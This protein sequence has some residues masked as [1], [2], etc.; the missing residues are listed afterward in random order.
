[1]PASSDWEELAVDSSHTR[2]THWPAIVQML[3]VVCELSAITNKTVNYQVLL[4]VQML[5]V[6]RLIVVCPLSLANAC[7]R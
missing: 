4:I 7:C 1:M 5:I 2:G 6:Q 3:I